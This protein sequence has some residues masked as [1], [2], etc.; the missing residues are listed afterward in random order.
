MRPLLILLHELN[1]WTS[2]L[3]NISRETNCVYSFRI[4]PVW[5]SVD[6]WITDV[7]QNVYIHSDHYEPSCLLYI[8]VI[9][10]VYISDD[11]Q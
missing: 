5:L 9:L 3:E 7:Y 8:C 4:K 1:N 6:Y 2:T 11:N 10:N